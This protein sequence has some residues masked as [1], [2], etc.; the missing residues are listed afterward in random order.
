MHLL[1]PAEIPN[2]RVERADDAAQLRF[3][4]RL[5]GHALA[6]T[7]RCFVE[8]PLEHG[9]VLAKRDR[10]ANPLQHFLQELRDLSA[11]DGFR[12]RLSPLNLRL[13]SRLP[14][15]AKRYGYQHQT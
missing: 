1:S 14:F 2:L 10:R 7:L 6:D 11:L 8:N 3:D 9:G 12:C 13:T 5:I 4:G 15:P